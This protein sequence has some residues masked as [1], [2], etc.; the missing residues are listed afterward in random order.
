MNSALLL[1]GS[2][3]VAVAVGLFVGCGGR[4]EADYTSDAAADDTSANCGNGRIEKGEECD[5]SHLGG[6]N[7]ASATMNS[8]STGQL[9]CDKQCKLDTSSCS[10][11]GNP[12][13]GGGTGTGGGNGTGGGFGTGGRLGTGGGLGTGGRVGGSGGTSGT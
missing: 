3:L 10:G 1:R 13:T 2:G 9:S 5:G 12:G 6:A 7:C 11:N 4:V 8:R